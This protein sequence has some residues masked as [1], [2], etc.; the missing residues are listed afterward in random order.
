MKG[1]SQIISHALYIGMTILAISFLIIYINGLK[2]DID[3]QTTNSNMN[4][5]SEKIRMKIFDLYLLSDE[6]ELIPESGSNFTIAQLELSN[7]GYEVEL[8]ENKMVVKF[9]NYELNKTV[10]T[11]LLLSGRA[12]LPAYLRLIREN[13]NDQIIDIIEVSQ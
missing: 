8:F 5:V 9:G 12:K 13:K 11:N 7:M 4:F 3:Y 6:S 10:N 2:S 1:V